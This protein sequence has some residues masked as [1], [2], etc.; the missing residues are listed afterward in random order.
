M[1]STI[2]G[3]HTQRDLPLPLKLLF[4]P[5]A[6]AHLNEAGRKVSPVRRR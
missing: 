2:D 1:N 5:P 6:K 4:A 3:D